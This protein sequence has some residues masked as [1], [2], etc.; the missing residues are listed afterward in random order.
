LKYPTVK[1]Q[2]NFGPIILKNIK[3]SIAHNFGTVRLKKFQLS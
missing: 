2:K 3:I 1:L